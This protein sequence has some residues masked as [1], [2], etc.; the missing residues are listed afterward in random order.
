MEWKKEQYRVTDD[1]GEFHINEICELLKKTYWG[2]D[3]TEKQIKKSLEHSLAVGLF[4]GTRQIGFS[5]AVTDYVT[6]SWICD[7][8]V[9]D[10]YRSKG[11]GKW[12]LQ[13]LFDHP[14]II[15]TRM[16]LVTKDAQDLYRKYGF[17]DHPYG[18]M[19]KKDH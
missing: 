3:R 9:H 5:R 6:F 18:C 7:V 10:D 1:A 19:L 11:L 15:S 16:I 2:F 12:M 17:I 13:C 8:V 4:D 14:E